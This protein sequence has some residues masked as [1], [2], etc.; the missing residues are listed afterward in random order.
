MQSFCIEYLG[1]LDFAVS[2]RAGCTI[3]FPRYEQG[4]V[5]TGLSGAPGKHPEAAVLLGP[6]KYDVQ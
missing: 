4:L 6:F 1:L 3:S 5:W 2:A